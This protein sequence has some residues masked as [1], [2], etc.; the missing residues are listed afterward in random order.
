LIEG[1]IL[2]EA[3]SFVEKL[4]A[5]NA[6]YGKKNVADDPDSKGS[7]D[8]NS[9]FK[10][11]PASCSTT[12]ITE[13]FGSVDSSSDEDRDM[14]S[15]KQRIIDRIMA[16]FYTLFDTTAGV[17]QRGVHSRPG[18]GQ[19]SADFAASASYNG[20]CSRR[21]AGKRKGSG[22]KGNGDSG[23]ESQKPAKRIKAADEVEEP[24]RRLAC[25]Y[26][27]RNPRK[28]WKTHPCLGPGWDST[29]RLK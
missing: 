6:E 4:V 24:E 1:D 23:D 17:T 18:H 2:N 21:Q 11:S 28:Y 10:L 7:G 9:H 15:Q 16:D 20:E 22:S 14:V 19:L 12:E 13:S 25:P 3:A 26:F 27:K 29:H 5:D 8:A